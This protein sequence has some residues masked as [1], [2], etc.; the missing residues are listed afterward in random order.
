MQ[1]KTVLTKP[2]MT[3]CTL[4]EAIGEAL[5]K[6]IAMETRA[7]DKADTHTEVMAQLSGAKVLLVEDNEMNQELAMELLSQ[8]QMKVVPW[9]TT[10]R[11]PWT[12]SK[13]TP[14]STAC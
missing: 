1:F 3:A 4:L 10:A 9:P 14:R 13:P 12:S 2:A 8:A 5:D 11:R 7:T 6:G